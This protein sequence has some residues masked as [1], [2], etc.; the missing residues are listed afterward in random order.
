MSEID[1]LDHYHNIGER[2][3]VLRE[4]LKARAGKSAYDFSARKKGAV[5]PGKDNVT[6]LREEIDRLEN[7]QK[8]HDPAKKRYDL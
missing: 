4:R 6:A 5:K 2:L 8:K 7:L 1:P 3:V